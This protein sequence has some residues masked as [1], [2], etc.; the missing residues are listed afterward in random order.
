MSCKDKKKGVNPSIPNPIDKLAM[1]S[2]IGVPV[3]LRLILFMVGLLF[4]PVFMLVLIWIM[5][6][7]IV[8]NNY[9]AANQISDMVINKGKQLFE[10]QKK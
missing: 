2:G 9:N 5:Y 3:W 10:K 8:L 1:K 6:D 7:Y 4:T